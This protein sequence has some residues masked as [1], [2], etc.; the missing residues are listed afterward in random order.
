MKTSALDLAALAAHRYL[1]GLDDRQVAATVS[2][3]ELLSRFDVPLGQAGLPAEQVV[4][5]LVRAA[6][7]GQLG[8]ASGRF[9]AWVIGGTL[10]S[11]LAADW[12]ASTWDQN[13]AI[14]ATSPAASVVEEIAGKWLLDV[15]RL[16]GTASFA[17]TTGC[18]MAHFTA[19]AAAREHLLAQA[20]WQVGEQGLAGSPPI[21]VLAS[22]VRHVSVDR[23]LRY[24]GVGARQIVVLPV[25]GA[26]AITPEVLEAALAAGDGPTIVSLNAADLNTGAF[27]PFSTLIPLAHA[28]GAWVHVDGAFGLF[29]R[30][31]ERCNSL[32]EGMDLADSWATDCHKWLNVPQDCG[33]AAVRN[34]EAH[35]RAFTIHDSYFVGEQAARDQI[36]WTPEWSR[37]ARGFSVYAAL[38]EL[39]RD[40]LAAMIERHCDQ[41]EA[42][43]QGIG[44]LPGAEIVFPAR[45]NQ[46]LVRFL[47][48]RPE[49]TPADHDATTDRIID[50]INHSGEAFFGG[51]TWNGRR[52]MRISVVNWRTTGADV[53]RTVAAVARALSA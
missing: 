35:R 11:A 41:C 42:L 1:D 43:V 27:D 7:G 31:S 14:Y 9:F 39:G 5:D 13:A 52:A 53:E 6:E 46:G 19:L 23:A 2:R 15:L 51:V 40:G 22:A 30:A 18:Q 47:D 21:R 32:V 10:P 16:P 45:L 12:L 37:R 49:A 34:P 25:D 28:Q 29:A 50:A 8:N 44:A 36:D 4:D 20:G 48:P 3:E 38:R 33:F 24:L 26:G 17:F